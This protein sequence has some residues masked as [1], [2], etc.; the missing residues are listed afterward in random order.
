MKRKLA[1]FAV[2]LGA[3]SLSFSGQ[4]EAVT[5]LLG[6]ELALVFAGTNDLAALLALNEVASGRAGGARRWAWVAL[7][8]SGGTALGLNTWHAIRTGSLPWLAA[9]VA[10]AEPVLLAWVLSHVVALAAGNG[11][12][13]TPVSASEVASR[14]EDHEPAAAPGQASCPPADT[15]ISEAATQPLPTDSGPAQEPLPASA[16]QGEHGDEQPELEA[17]PDSGEQSEPDLPVQLIDRAE[18]LER[19]ARA[20]SSGKR[21]LAYREA[22]RRLGV[23]YDTARAALD[24][25]R[26]RID[27][28][29]NSTRS[30]AAA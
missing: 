14:R 10:G 8:L 29:S 17:L 27:V 25:A 11:K 30:S 2:M 4:V 28:E 3:L 24:A 19:Q 23:R 20:H 18:K 13:E 12:T 7:L 22:P 21:G 16:E 5:P 15:S 26:A 1:L 6:S 9:V